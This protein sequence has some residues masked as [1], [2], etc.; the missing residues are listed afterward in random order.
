M[1]RD[2]RHAALGDQR[3]H[4][5]VG[6]AAADVVDERGPGLQRGGGDLGAHGVDRDR[7]HRRCSAST[8]G[9][10]RRSSSAGARPLGARPGGLAADVEEVG[11]LRDELAAVGDGGLG[12][13][14]SAPPSL[15][16]SGVTLTTPMT[17]GRPARGSGRV[18]VPVT[19]CRRG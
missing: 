11:A 18:T 17:S 15:N 8:T 19:A 13:R 14:T 6:Q 7:R 1:H 10:T 9:R 3:G 2:E 16:E 5:G 12:R 4:L